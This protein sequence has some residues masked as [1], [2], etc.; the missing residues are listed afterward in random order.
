MPKLIEDAAEGNGSS[1]L[2]KIRSG[3]PAD[4]ALRFF[5]TF[6]RRGS[7]ASAGSVSVP[8]L[9]PEHADVQEW[10]G[11]GKADSGGTPFAGKKK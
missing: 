2:D 10:H 7:S 9:E 4:R 3:L 8:E 5:V 6:F 1:V 11:E